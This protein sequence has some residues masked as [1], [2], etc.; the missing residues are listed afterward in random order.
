M[1]NRQNER[2]IPIAPPLVRMMNLVTHDEELDYLLKMGT[3]LYDYETALAAGNLPKDQFKA[4]LDKMKRKGLIHVEV[5]S[6]GKEEYRLNAIAVG[7]YE[8]MMHYLVGKPEERAFSEEWLAFFKF[9]KKFNFF[10]LR[11]AQDLFLRNYL[12][13]N[14]DAALL[15][16][17]HKSQNKRKTI[18]IN[19]SIS[20]TAQVYPTFQVDELVKKFGEQDAIFAFP[21]V[22]R[23]G[24]TVLDG[25]C[26]F[27]MPKESCVAFGSTGSQWASYGYGRKISKA[28]ALEIFK[29]VRE[30]GAVHSVIHEKDDERLPVA[31]ICNCCW[32]CCGI[33]KSY[34]MGALSLMYNASYIAHI[35][36]DSNCKGCGTCAKFCPTTAMR[37]NDKK[38]SFNEAKCIGCGQCAFQCRQNN[39][40]LVP[41]TRTVYLPILKK[42][43]IRVST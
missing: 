25:D 19:A 16:P 24:K 11:N 13:P 41:Q 39:I 42:S 18:P 21:C 33:L 2:F 28:E 30:K 15:D 10:P 5:D 36:T 38:I 8:V 22:C 37:E 3:G 40:E 32:D 4:F 14:Q 7:W 23:H 26:A 35:K 1:M 6:A 43:E 20:N 29:E 27:A 12:K 31:A 34:N 17:A 9:F